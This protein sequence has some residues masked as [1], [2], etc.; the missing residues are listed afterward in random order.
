MSKVVENTQ[1]NQEYDLLVIGAGIFGATLALE[2]SQRGLNVLLVDKNDFGSATSANSLKTIHAGLRYLQSMDVR[3]SIIS[4][5]ERKAWL[6]IAPGLVKPLPCILPTTKDLM[7]SRLVVGAGILFYNLLTL[8]RNTGMPNELQI[9]A[10]HLIPKSLIKKYLPNLHD[11]RVTG[12]ACWYDA[13]AI[14]TERLVLA[15]IL[16]AKESGARVLNYQEVEQLESCQ[17]SYQAQLTGLNERVL[18]RFVVDCS[19]R[20]CFL[21]KQTING[22]DTPQINDLAYV[23]AVNVII[24]KKLSS[25]AFGIK[26]K[27][28]SGMTRLLFTAPWQNTLFEGDYTLVGTWYYKAGAKKDNQLSEQELAQCIKQVNS[29]FETPICSVKDIVQVHV[30]YLPAD[31]A[32]LQ[33]KGPDAS[34]IKHAKLIPWS[35]AGGKNGLYSLKGT[36]FT[37]A[38]RAAEETINSINKQYGLNLSSSRSANQPLWQDNKASLGKLNSLG[39]TE[40]QLEFVQVYFSAALAK[41]VEVCEGDPEMMA[42]I[43]SAEYCFRGLFEYCFRY[44]Y[45]QHLTDLLIRRIPIGSGS[46]PSRNTVQYG[47]EFLSGKLLWDAKRQQNEV[48][49]LE[50]YYMKYENETWK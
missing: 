47:L 40:E 9:P 49:A 16:A 39:L 43:P 13:Q 18:A 17:G 32:R 38:R 30:G 36:K 29:A 28:D 31:K 37:L 23:K 25:H 11:S 8:G 3:S 21:E 41:I 48:A 14:N 45:V 2:A 19:G 50:A 6:T 5:K 27:D 26:V 33:A 44:E 35:G 1:T 42:H 24:N 10:A 15:C 4:A 7:K 34:L 12:G 22:M 20:S 46:L